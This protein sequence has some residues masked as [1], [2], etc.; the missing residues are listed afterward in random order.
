MAKLPDRKEDSVESADPR[1][2]TN[3]PA[4]QQNPQTCSVPENICVDVDGDGV[5]ETSRETNEKNHKYFAK[6]YLE[7]Q[8]YALTGLRLIFVN[9]R[10]FKIQLVL[11]ILVIVA[12]FVF[13]LSHQDWVAL[14]L[15]IALVLV[16]EAFNSVIEAICDTISKEYR[17]N[18]KYAKDVSAGAVLLSAVLALFAGVIIFSPYVWEL[19]IEIL[20]TYQ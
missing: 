12:G 7:S 11:A 15:V 19:L 2:G 17:V 13:N 1:G 14:T 20:G 18:I 9:E 5:T 10:N 3:A 8:Q 6:S 4:D 16:T